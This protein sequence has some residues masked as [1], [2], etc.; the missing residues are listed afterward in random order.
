[1]EYLTQIQTIKIEVVYLAAII[2]V[3]VYLD[4]IQIQD[5]LAMTKQIEFFLKGLI[6]T[7]E[8]HQVLCLVGIKV[9]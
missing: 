3:E 1:M 2:K 5:K 8:I 9:V 6:R 4:Q 7:I